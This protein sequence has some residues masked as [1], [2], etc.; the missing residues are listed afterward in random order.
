M[1][2]LKLPSSTWVGALVPTEL[3]GIVMYIFLHEEPGPCPKAALLFLG[4]SS[5]VS[6]S[7]LFPD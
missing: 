3:K 6:V 5:L 2:S 4:G 1:L 7:L